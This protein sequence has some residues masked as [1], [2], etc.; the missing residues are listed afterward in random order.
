MGGVGKCWKESSSLP[1]VLGEIYKTGV[2]SEFF[3]NVYLRVL[4]KRRQASLVVK[5]RNKKL[6][7]LAIENKELLP[8]CIFR[9]QGKQTWGMSR[10]CLPYWEIYFKLE[11][12][13]RT[14]FLQHTKIYTENYFNYL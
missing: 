5:Y 10:E 3:L 4:G 11:S 7:L 13:S 12:H 6:F 1:G 14:F 9:D 2:G 8:S